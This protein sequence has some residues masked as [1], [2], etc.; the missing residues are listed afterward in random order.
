MFWAWSVGTGCRQSAWVSSDRVMSVGSLWMSL[1]RGCV[2]WLA[3]CV[4][5]DRDDGRPGGEDAYFW[6]RENV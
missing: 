4:N 2:E 6:T 1:F 5:V 3:E